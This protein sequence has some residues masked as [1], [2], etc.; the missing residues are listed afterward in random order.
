[1]YHATASPRRIGPAE[2]KARAEE[3]ARNVEGVTEVQNRLAVKANQEP[4]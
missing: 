3:L 2:Q 1:M 4:R